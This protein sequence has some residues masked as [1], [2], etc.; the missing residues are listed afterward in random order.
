MMNFELARQE[1][2][3]MK[4]K[5]FLDA[6]CVSV[7]PE[8]AVKA[9]KKFAEYSATCPE[10]SSSA[11]HV[12]M[13]MMRQKALDEVIKLTKASSEEI[14]LVE[15]TTHGLNIA[16]T[17]IKLPPGSK[18]LIS[19]LE[20]L[21]VP[22]P[23]SMQ[24]DSGIEIQL[25]KNRDG[26]VLVED[27][28]KSIDDRVKMIVISSVQWCNGWLVD[29][30][31]LGE[32]CKKKGIYLIVDA[33]HQV[34]AVNMDLS[35]VHVDILT[36]GGH[37]WLNSPYGCG[38]LYVNKEIVKQLKPVFWGYL[39]LGEPEGGWP[40]YFGTPSITPVRDWNF[41]ETAK[42]FEIGG[43]SNYAGA[44]AL[45]ESLSLFNELGIENIEKHNVGLADYLI[46]GLKEIGATLITRPEPGHRSALVVFRF[47][48]DIKEE[49]ELLKELHRNNVYV[50]MRFTSNVGGIRVSCHFFNNRSDID[51]LIAQLKKAYNKKKPDFKA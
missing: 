22:I 48:N 30:K 44:I 23:W 38:F 37:K 26:R 42:K 7:A 16:A 49:N 2:P 29:L 10:E 25:I 12:A 13:D 32:L 17:S 20:F 9:V 28:E 15:S 31:A 19:D 36:A 8:R 14:A 45:G 43:T 50:A 41:V 47:Y 3:I 33:I 5:A 24:K 1:F 6:A 40:A 27:F 35:Q 34:G 39:N 11:H 21:Q 51:A 4:E 46:E 18:V